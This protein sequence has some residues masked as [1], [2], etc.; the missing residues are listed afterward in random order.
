MESQDIRALREDVKNLEHTKRVLI[1]EKNK[2]EHKAEKELIAKK[3]ELT[4]EINQLK[5]GNPWEA[6]GW[7]ILILLP[8][9][10]L[11]LILL[12]F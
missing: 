3:K 7:A 11:G 10:L 8:A 6:I 4:K 1:R 2:K 5:N 9:S 12:E